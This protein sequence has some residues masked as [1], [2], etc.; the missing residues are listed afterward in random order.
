MKKYLLVV[1]TVTLMSCG[2][3]QKHNLQITK[4]HTIDDLRADVDALYQQ[5]QKHHPKLYLYTPKTEM[6]AKFD[7]LK[8]S[9][10]APMNSRDFYKRVAPVLTSVRQ[11][12]VSI[13][14][15]GRHFTKKERKVLKKKKFEFY[16][17][18]FEYLED[19]LW[20]ERTFGKDSSFVGA[21]VVSIEGE[22]VGELV[23]TYKTRFASDGYNTTLYNRAVGKGFKSLYV[24]DKG[25]L[26]S[27][28]VTFKM[29][30]STFVK[31][32]KRIPKK[33]KTQ[34]KDSLKHNDSIKKPKREAL[35]KAEK[36]ANRIVAK[37]R[38]KDNKKYGY[39]PRTKTYTRHLEF[40]GNDS[41]IAYMKIRS[42]T[43]GNYKKFYKESFTKLDSAKTQHLILDL[44]DN[45]GGRIAEIDKLYSYLTNDA[46]V[47]LNPVEVNSRFPLL[48]ALFSNST[49]T[50]LKVFGAIFSVNPITLSYQYFKTKKQDGKLYFKMKYNKEREPNPLRYKGKMYVLTN[51]NSFSASSILSTH[52][53]A[54]ERATFVGEETGGAYNGN[55]AGFY[56]IYEMTTS[57]LIVRIGLMQIETPHKTEPDGY[58]VKPDVEI[59]PTISDFKQNKDPELEWVLHHIE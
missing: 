33:K 34:A 16:D 30:D 59:L 49:P 5:L 57:K 54:T 6:D 29:K 14:P 19:T 31:H 38:K 51:G 9:I 7:S 10:I 1:F 28:D 32:F 43:N 50:L 55:V 36:K 2:S 42:F 17:L 56:K 13:R 12:H 4:L 25:F 3:V 41:T 26:D 58:G 46:Y 21:S 39:V 15:Q 24:K 47:F 22:S 44:R 8:R 20:V 35:T 18:D 53:K 52:L 48:T 27:L 40:I 45:G 23:K 37:K 11:G